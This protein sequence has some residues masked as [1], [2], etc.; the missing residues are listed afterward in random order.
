MGYLKNAIC[1][2]HFLIHKFFF[3]AGAFIWGYFLMQMVGHIDV[4]MFL[5]LDIPFIN[6]VSFVLLWIITSL[7]LYH[8]SNLLGDEIKYRSKISRK[9]LA[10]I[11]ERMDVIGQ[12]INPPSKY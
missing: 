10:F 9:Y 4:A 3:N 5:G 11:D 8:F 2:I 12:H 1:I 7:L 6:Y